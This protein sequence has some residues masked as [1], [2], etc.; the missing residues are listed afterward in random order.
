MCKV[1]HKK[2]AEMCKLNRHV[3]VL[4]GLALVAGCGTAQ[5]AAIPATSGHSGG[6]APSPYAGQEQRPI[7]TLSSQDVDD[8]LNGRGWGL[9]KAA[10]LNGVPGPLHVLELHAELELS[11]DQIEQIE[12]LRRD[13]TS[14]AVP[15]GKQ[16]V[17]LEK[18]LNER[19]A[20]RTVDARQLEELLAAIASIHGRLR[21]VHLAAHLETAEILTGEQVASYNRLRGYDLVEPCSSV[22]EGH[23]SEMWRRHNRCTE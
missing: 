3:F 9:A 2:A 23:D 19:F 8:L 5:E 16:Y 7:K 15:L 14:E 1:P 13:M 12:A 21:F 22:P 20:R 10:E 18:Q 6:H 11:D 17:E 4:L